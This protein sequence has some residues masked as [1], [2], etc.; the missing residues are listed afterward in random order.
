MSP[1]HIYRYF[2]TSLGGLE[3]VGP[4]QF[5]IIIKYTGQL[6]PDFF[7]KTLTSMMLDPEVAQW[8]G[9]LQRT[10]FDNMV[11]DS[12][13]PCKARCLSYFFSTVI[14]CH[15]QSNLVRRNLFTLFIHFQ[16]VRVPDRTAEW[17]GGRQLEQQL[18]AHISN[19]KQ[20]AYWKWH[21][22]FETLKPT[23][24]VRVLQSHRTYGM[25]L[26]I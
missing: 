24:L 13:S 3:K 7:V 12:Q 8:V 6:F 22:S 9:H 23:A 5:A 14:K 18:R 20:R 25:D 11:L 10:Y 16:E 2:G 19:R 26:F 1:E 15:C 21:Q 17:A 4:Q